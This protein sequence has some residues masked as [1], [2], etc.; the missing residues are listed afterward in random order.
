M[1]SSCCSNVA[2]WV[3]HGQT[4]IHPRD[5]LGFRDFRFYRGPTVWHCRRHHYRRAGR[6]DYVVV[7]AKKNPTAQT[8]LQY[9]RTSAFYLDSSEY[10]FLPNRACAP[11]SFP[12]DRHFDAS[13]LASVCCAVL[14]TKQL[15][16]GDC[17]QFLR[18]SQPPASVATKL[19][20]AFS[21]IPERS[22]SFYLACIG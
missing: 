1:V 22:L 5:P 20:V 11:R 17:G 10:L 15:A 8:P 14:L 4:S 2:E 19:F 9:S 21:L 3:D 12:G 7:V 13:Q 6:L 16:D 18:T